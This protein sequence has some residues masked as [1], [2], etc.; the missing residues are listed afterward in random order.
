[1]IGGGGG[2][3]ILAV[4]PYE[5]PRAGWRLRYVCL[6][7]QKL[8]EFCWGVHVVGVG[9]VVAVPTPSCEQRAVLAGR[10][11]GGRKEAEE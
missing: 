1:M 5:E 9:G 4:V 11:E 8:L 7:E 2:F 3:F 10:R 6:Q